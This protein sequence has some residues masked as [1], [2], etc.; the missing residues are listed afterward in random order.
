MVHLPSGRPVHSYSCW[1][2]IMGQILT[3]VRDFKVSA[4]PAVTTTQKF[5]KDCCGV[6][7]MNEDFKAQ[8]VGL[9]VTATDSAVL[10]ISKLERYSFDDAILKELGVKPETSVHH[11]AELLRRNKNS[12]EVSIVYLRGLDEKRWAVDTRWNELRNGWDVYARPMKKAMREWHAGRVV[13]S[14]LH[15]GK[16]LFRFLSSSIYT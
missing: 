10:S 6:A 13:V 2:I 4:H 5:W 1:R 16:K 7:W 3:N 15:T 14:R 9:E 12:S 8:F 11:F